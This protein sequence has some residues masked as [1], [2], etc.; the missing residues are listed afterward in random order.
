MVIIV[1][2]RTNWLISAMLFRKEFQKKYIYKRKEKNC[3]KHKK[4]VDFLF[5]YAAMR[6]CFKLRTYIYA[7]S[8]VFIKPF[9]V[10][11]WPI[12]S[13]D[14]LSFVYLSSQ[15]KVFR[16]APLPANM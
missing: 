14:I 15:A 11:S 5:K 2:K 4:Y 3:I 8:A 13:S 6:R 7:E 10:S 12:F 16:S 1:Q 9:V